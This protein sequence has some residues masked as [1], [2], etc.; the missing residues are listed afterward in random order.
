[1]IADQ[2]SQHLVSST[3]CTANPTPAHR[4][5]SGSCRAGIDS[6]NLEHVHH[7]LSMR[8]KA[9]SL[10]TTKRQPTDRISRRKVPACM[11]T[12]QRAGAAAIMTKGIGHYTSSEETR[13]QP[14][15]KV[16]HTP[17]IRFLNKF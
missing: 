3:D 7:T 4:Q 8:R 14:A 17:M 10:N 13:W 9:E 6:P 1:M 11:R 15:Q 12:L 16:E 2:L 5:V